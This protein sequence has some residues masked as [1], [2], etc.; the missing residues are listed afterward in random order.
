MVNKR[1]GPLGGGKGMGIP[2]GRAISKLSCGSAAVP[3]ERMAS[4]SLS[5]FVLITC[6]IL[7]FFFSKN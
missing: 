2:F 6:F 1:T 5:I 7:R 4:S 3:G